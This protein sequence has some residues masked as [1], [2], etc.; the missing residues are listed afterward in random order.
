MYFQRRGLTLALSSPSGAGKTTL[1]KILLQSEENL[2]S[3]VSF[4]TRPPRSGEIDGKD[5]SFVSKE[6]FS[7]MITDSAFLEY[8]EVH[9]NLYGTPKQFVTKSLDAGKDLL[10]DIDWQ[11]AKAL[12]NSNLCVSPVTIFILPPS[13]A[14]LEKR[15]K[16]RGADDPEVIARRLHNAR[17]EIAH[18][19]EYD[20]VFVNDNPHECAEQIRTVLQA[21]RLKR[22]RQTGL[23]DFIDNLQI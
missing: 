20:Y 4:T 2:I 23:P 12:R 19:A 7:A 11:G 22:I 1:S 21:E 14:E 8:A 6:K 10:F 9:G 17:E 16:G 15:L 5:Y 18:W 3:S 13:G